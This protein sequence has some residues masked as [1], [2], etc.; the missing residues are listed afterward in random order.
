MYRLEFLDQNAVRFQDAVVRVGDAKTAHGAFRRAINHTGAKARTRTVRALAKQMGLKQSVVRTRIE[1]RKANYER[2]EYVLKGSGEPL[3]LKEFG[4]KQFAYGVRAKP[5][6]RSQRFEGVFIMAGSRNSG[7]P[8]AGGHVFK[9]TNGSASLPIE[10]LYGP[11]IPR[12]MVQGASAIAFSEVTKD[13]GT[14]IQH[15][16]GRLTGGVVG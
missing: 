2:L 8:V 1:E 7:R 9:R 13:L 3:S 10:K 15:E 16:L 6:G 5:W 11:S 14:R 4:A 12:E